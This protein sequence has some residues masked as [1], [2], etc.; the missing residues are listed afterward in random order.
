MSC[1]CKD[2]DKDKDKDKKKTYDAHLCSIEGFVLVA[3]PL[4]T[5][6]TAKCSVRDLVLPLILQ[7]RLIM[8][9]PGD[10]G[11]VFDNN[12]DTAIISF[13]TVTG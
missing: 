2:K 7:S 3:P 8:M 1:S 10:D 9:M 5:E 13:K 11:D 4:D 6:D 12:D